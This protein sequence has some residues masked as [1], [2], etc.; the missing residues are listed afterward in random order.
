MYV[1]TAVQEVTSYMREHTHKYVHK[2]IGKNTKEN[3]PLAVH[4]H[5][6]Q[7]IERWLCVPSKVMFLEIY[8]CVCTV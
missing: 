2:H 6:W 4:I 3:Q 7:A 8:M 1:F 5:T